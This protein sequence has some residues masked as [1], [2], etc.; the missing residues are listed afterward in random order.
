MFSSTRLHASRG[1]HAAV[2]ERELLAA[3]E[4]VDVRVEVAGEPEAGQRAAS[5]KEDF[6]V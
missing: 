5:D 2:D 3:V 4:E 6:G 1:A